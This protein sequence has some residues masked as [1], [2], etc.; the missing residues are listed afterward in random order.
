MGEDKVAGFR[1]RV[2]RKAGFEQRLVARW[3]VSVESQTVEVA[4]F[5]ATEINLQS[6]YPGG[7]LVTKV[8]VPS[9]SARP[10]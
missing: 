10:D 6:R 2:A 5:V 8:G 1:L 4:L 3:A 7:I 9:S